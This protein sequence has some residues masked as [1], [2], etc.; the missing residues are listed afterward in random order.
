MNA[1]FRRSFTS[2]L[3]RVKD[4]TLIRRVQE[5]IEKV[6]LATTLDDIGN[7]KRSQGDGVYYRIRVGNYRIGLR[8]EGSTVTFV[9]FLHRRD[10]Y[11]YFP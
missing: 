11:R 5:V 2:D 4:K 6:E 10:I 3:K 9:R 7:V 1:V 8:I